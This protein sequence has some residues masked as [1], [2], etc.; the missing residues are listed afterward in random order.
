MG[1]EDTNES[2]RLTMTPPNGELTLGMIGARD[3]SSLLVFV[4]GIAHDM[5]QD[6]TAIKCALTSVA[7]EGRMDDSMRELADMAVDRL[8]TLVSELLSAG[9]LGR[10][11]RI[12]HNL[13]DLVTRLVKL[14]LKGTDIKSEISLSD[15]MDLPRI[16]FLDMARVLQNLI[17]NACKA[18]GRTGRLTVRAENGVR[19]GLSVLRVTV[20]DSG[21]GLPPDW[22]DILKGNTPSPN[23]SN[24]GLGIRICLKILER[25]N[26]HLDVESEKDKG[27]TF[28]VDIPLNGGPY[29]PPLA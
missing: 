13:D 21:P 5:N 19:G 7:Y 11:P 27:T 1:I 22:M 3:G 29:A 12:I 17:A 26:G 25:Y 2:G 28:R 8:A 14:C 16:D 20:A 23:G 6:L 18:M 10:P 4:Q 9:R 15:G 24:H